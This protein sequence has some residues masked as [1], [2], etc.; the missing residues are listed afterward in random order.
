MNWLVSGFPI[1]LDFGRNLAESHQIWLDIT[2]F[3]RS[4]FVSMEIWPKFGR[5]LT[6]FGRLR[7]ELTGVWPSLSRSGLDSSDLSL[8]E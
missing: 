5:D 2:R 3:G 7:V 1:S 4:S 8:S 6:R